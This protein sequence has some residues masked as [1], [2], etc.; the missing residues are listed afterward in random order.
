MVPIPFYSIVGA[1]TNNNRISLFLISKIRF[2]VLRIYPIPPP[3]PF[4]IA[5]ERG[6]GI[7]LH[8]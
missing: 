5:I 2:I 1:L 4:I 3:T 7:G 8:H 6:R